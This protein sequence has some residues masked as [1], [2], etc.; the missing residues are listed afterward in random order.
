[1]HPETAVSRHF[2]SELISCPLNAELLNTLV[3]VFVAALDG[4]FGVLFRYSLGL[5][6]VLGLMYLLLC[7]GQ[8]MLQQVLSSY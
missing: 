7:V 3:G 8:M 5:V 6:S 1:L 2:D 4:A